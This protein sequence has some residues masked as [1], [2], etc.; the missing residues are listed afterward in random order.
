MPARPARSSLVSRTLLTTASLLVTACGPRV[1]RPRPAPSPAPATPTTTTLPAPEPVASAATPV[2]GS[3]GRIVSW[4]PGFSRYVV[5]SQAA[6]QVE[7]DTLVPG[8]VRDDSVATRAYLRMRVSPESAPDGVVITVDSFLVSPRRG[9]PFARTLMYPIVFQA[10]L[11]PARLRMEFPAEQPMM[12]TPCIGPAATL[13]ALA[14]DLAP[15]LP[16]PLERGR[17]W[18]DSTTHQLCRS[19]VPLT[20]TSRHAW[21]VEGEVEQGG[22]TFVRLVRATE[23]TIAGIGSGRRAGASVD[24]AGRAQAEYLLDPTVGRLH[25]AIVNST[26]ELRVRER[27]DA[28][29]LVTRQQARQEAVLQD[30]VER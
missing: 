18:S 9:A 15:A 13:L 25:S 3:T 21:T 26:A 30:G 28:P 27:P 12:G 29:E 2:P 10:M 17:T 22:R 6:V 8:G 19:G 16:T 23:S 14:R 11:D 20:V 24:G 7:G 1:P 4:M 5:T